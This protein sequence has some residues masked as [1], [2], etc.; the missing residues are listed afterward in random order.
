ME[1]STKINIPKSDIDISHK[2]RVLMFGSCFIEN[3]GKILVD[4]K[5]NV[6]LNPFGILYNPASIARALYMLLDNYEFT[7]KDIFEH[8]GLFNSFYHHGSFSDTDKE[9]YLSKIN[10]ST[11]Q[12]VDDLKK[13]DVL[14]I[15]LGTSYVFRHKDKDIVVGNCHKLP[16][17][18]FIRYRLTVSEIVDEWTVLIK[19]IRQQ[20]PPK[21]KLYLQ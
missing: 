4:N 10:Q 15:T 7:E 17:A 20:N 18:D 21:L 8:K 1:F 19:Q 9:N 11:K 3:I 6:N 14:I 16:A 2:H 5:F 12:A 13:S